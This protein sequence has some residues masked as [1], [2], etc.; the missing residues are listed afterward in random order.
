MS[1]S[2]PAVDKQI[3]AH[4]AASPFPLCTDAL[5][6]KRYGQPTHPTCPRVPSGATLGFLT[7]HSCHI[8]LRRT[9]CRGI[10][11]GEGGLLRACHHRPLPVHP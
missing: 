4:L 3:R 9:V 10:D 1:P 2:S 8:G 5:K 6:L 7:T 11:A